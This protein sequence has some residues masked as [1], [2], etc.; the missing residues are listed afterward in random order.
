MSDSNARRFIDAYNRLD[1][2]MRDIYNI[3]PSLS[4]S[5]CVR[6][7]AD[8]NSVIRKYEDDIIEYGRL[9]NAIVHRSGEETIAEPNTKVVE[10]LES[11]ARLICTPPR[12]MDTVANRSV[13]SV[14]AKTSLS[15]VLIQLF[16]TGYSIV[17]VYD[18]GTLIGVI[19]RRLIVES[20]G[21]GVAANVDLNDLLKLSV[22]E[23]LDLKS[24]SVTYEVVDAN[25]TIDSILYLFQSN[26]N[27]TVV[28]IT[29]NGNY[30]ESPLGVVVTSDT[31]DM[32]SILDNY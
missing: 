8:I 17:P 1:K 22:A 16:Q 12:V 13:Y 32:Q 25:V 9:R 15:E 10:K 5:D 2:G 31:I 23:A 19:N 24:T 20:I 30:N 7:V 11:I 6:K 14:S 27:L 18:N 4:F 3:K 26:R 28:I 29:K 21:A